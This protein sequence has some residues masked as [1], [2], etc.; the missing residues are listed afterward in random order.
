MIEREDLLP[1]ER[2]ARR[3][4]R[5]RLERDRSGASRRRAGRR[6]RRH[7]RR[8]PRRRARAATP[9][10]RGARASR[11]DR[12]RAPERRSRSA[13]CSPTGAPRNRRRSSPPPRARPAA[14]PRG[15]RGRPRGRRRSSRTSR[16][17]PARARS[18]PARPC[19]RRAGPA[20]SEASR[21]GSR[22]RWRAPRPGATAITNTVPLRRS[23]RSIHPIS[24]PDATQVR[25]AFASSGAAIPACAWCDLLAGGARGTRVASAG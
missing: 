22:P 8:H 23:A 19:A 6:R 11:R 1:R 14:R 4:C 3:A 2:N 18:P 25:R 15:S 7:P 12:P 16:R 13:S 17:T 9:A 10:R 24:G 5:H 21:C 20:H